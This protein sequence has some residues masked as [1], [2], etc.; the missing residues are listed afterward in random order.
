MLVIQK[1][2]G[3]VR[4][5]EIGPLAYNLSE[6]AE[7]LHVSRPTMSNLIHLEGFPVIKIGER[8]YLIPVD[9]LRKWLS[10]Q[11]NSEL[12]VS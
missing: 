8:R 6:A 3:S 11:V 4:M 7:A 12:K 9:D 1:K 5:N 2:K 10:Q